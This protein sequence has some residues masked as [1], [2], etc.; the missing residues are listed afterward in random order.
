[1]VRFLKEPYFEGRR[2]LEDKTYFDIGGK[3]AALI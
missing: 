2:L 1:M 3:G